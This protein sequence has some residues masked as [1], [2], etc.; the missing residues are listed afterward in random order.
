M[1]RIRRIRY[2]VQRT[3]GPHAGCVPEE[4][5]ETAHR[6]ATDRGL[7]RVWLPLRKLQTAGGPNSWGFNLRILDSDGEVIPSFALDCLNPH[8]V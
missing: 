3:A 4:S 7:R 2:T 5:W 1:R 8:T 6:C